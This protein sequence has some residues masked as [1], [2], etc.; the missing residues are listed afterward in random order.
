ML[1]C[2]HAARTLSIHR[3][4]ARPPPPDTARV[5]AL[6]LTEAFAGLRNQAV[7]LAERAGLQTTMRTLHPHGPWLRLPARFWPDPVAMVSPAADAPLPATL[8]G[9]GG[10][11]A[12]VT[13]RLRRQ[14]HRAIHVQHPR[15]NPARFDLIV[16]QPHDNLTGPNVVV[17]RTA[18]H[19]VTQA[20]LAS[21]RARWS[22]VFAHLP[23]PLVS[24]LIGGSNGRYRLDAPVAT[25]LALQLATMMRMDQVSVAIT[26][27][28]RTDPLAM[29]ALKANLFPLGAWIW[30]GDGD[31]P[32]LGLL[33]CADLIIATGDSVSMISEAAA[34]AAPVMIA[35]LPGRSRRIA[36]F[37]QGLVAER[38]VRFYAGRY[39]PWPVAPLDDTDLAAAQLRDTLAR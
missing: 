36:A 6:I 24:V 26:P 11:A 20:K 3:I 5:D 34:T 14:G 35:R 2:T 9:C 17:T 15:M 10:V 32:Y 30:D 38:R 23:R 19:H 22:P 16:V 25:D 13:S 33:A 39:E 12:A 18:L 28:R 7:G 27:S 31:N 1:Q 8:I 37:T 4:D 29:G 21:A